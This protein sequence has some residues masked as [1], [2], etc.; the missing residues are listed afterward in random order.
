M[1][2]LLFANLSFRVLQI[3]STCVFE[4]RRIWSM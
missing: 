1:L 3:C 2:R 4:Y